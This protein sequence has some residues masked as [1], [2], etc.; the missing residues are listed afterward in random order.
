MAR[1]DDLAET[2]TP[3][4]KGA[5]ELFVDYETL[6]GAAMA[7]AI[8]DAKAICATCPFVE[9]CDEYARLVKPGHG[10][11]GGK[12]WRKGRVAKSV[13]SGRPRITNGETET[14]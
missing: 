7:H 12:L 4:C 14:A 10:V 9:M 6:T 5:P 8:D 3:E 13:L 1:W 2:D 11:W